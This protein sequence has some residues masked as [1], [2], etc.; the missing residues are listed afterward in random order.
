MSIGL[1]YQSVDPLKKTDFNSLGFLLCSTSPGGVPG[2]MR[3]YTSLGTAGRDVSPLGRQTLLYAR[4]TK[5][6]PSSG[7]NRFHR[8]LVQPGMLGMLKLLE[9]E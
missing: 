9:K 1:P 8:A 5:V 7:T 6:K 2:W 4:P 3:W